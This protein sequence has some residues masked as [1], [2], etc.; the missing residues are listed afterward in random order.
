M[1]ILNRKITLR[2]T[3][4]LKYNVASTFKKILINAD[5]PYY[6]DQVNKKW[7]RYFCD[8]Y[9]FYY[10]RTHKS[11]TIWLSN[12]LKKKILGFICHF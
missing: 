9:G 7:W 12:G 10:S 3:M 11:F 6:F 1:L 2:D 5:I 4:T 8:I